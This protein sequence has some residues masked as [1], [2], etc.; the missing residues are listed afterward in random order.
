MVEADRQ[1]Q[2]P[3]I[4]P[5]WPA[6]WTTP[7]RLDLLER[8]L[9]S[10]YFSQ[11]EGLRRIFR[12]IVMGHESPD[13]IGKAAMA[14]IRE[15]LKGYFQNEGA[16]EPLRITIAKGVQ[17]ATVELN[18]AIALDTGI[19]S[20]AS[21]KRRFWLA[22]WNGRQNAVIY[23]DLWAVPAAAGIQRTLWEI[24]AVAELRYGPRLCEDDLA[25][26]NLVILG[27]PWWK[28]PSMGMRFRL[29][30]QR[31]V[32]QTGERAFAGRRY[33]D[34]AGDRGEEYALLTRRPGLWPDTVVTSI[35][36]S[37]G[38]AIEGA[39]L[40]LTRDDATRVLTKAVEDSGSN[41]SFQ[42]LL[43]VDLAGP[44]E[45]VMAVEY[46]EFAPVA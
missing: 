16:T 18:T 27:W 2:N 34:A 44:D 9:R 43:R 28:E 1:S 12:A 36:A 17:Q 5:T 35:V 15:R 45:E 23:S 38:R 24:G 46:L 37:H 26:D 31:I 11:A 21:P 39:G 33:E 4:E 30:G 32:D 10:P 20:E 42:V 6:D 22:H 29:D 14:S 8:V 13:S 3:E 7:E 25:G 19:E 40:W 41:Y